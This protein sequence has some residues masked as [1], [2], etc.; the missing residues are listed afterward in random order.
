V[1]PWV[2][3]VNSAPPNSLLLI[4]INIMNS[5][6]VIA[7]IRDLAVLLRRGNIERADGIISDVVAHLET[8]IRSGADP[9]DIEMRRAQQTMFAMDEVQMLVSQQ[10]FEGASKA[11]SDAANEW[12]PPAPRTAKR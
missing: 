4:R 2:N 10:D 3:G 5:A 1:Q 6:D 7:N 8:V 12:Q 9:A 11:A